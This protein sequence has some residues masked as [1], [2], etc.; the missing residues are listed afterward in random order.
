[1]VAMQRAGDDALAVQ[2][3]HTSLPKRFSFPM[4]EIWM[5]Q[6]RLLTYTGKRALR[7]LEQ[8]RFRAGYDFLCLRAELDSSL[9]ERSDWWTRIQELPA[10]QQEEM[11]RQAPKPDQPRKRKR[12]RKYAKKS[13][14]EQ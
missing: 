9:Q 10:E 14:S 5:M 6:G 2:L 3:T 12:R 7:L 8:P 1:M 4:R 13:D 11:A